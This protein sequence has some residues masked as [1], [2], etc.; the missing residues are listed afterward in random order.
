M[1]RV[2]ELDA[3]DGNVHVYHILVGYCFSGSCH[4]RG[5]HLTFKRALTLNNSSIEYKR[6]KKKV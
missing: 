1:V 4:V 2:I 3:L 6:I 5:I